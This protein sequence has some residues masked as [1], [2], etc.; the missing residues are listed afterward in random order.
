MVSRAMSKILGHTARKNN[1]F[2]GMAKSMSHQPPSSEVRPGLEEIKSTLQRIM[3]E[4]KERYKVKYLGVFG[5]Y[6]RG[7]ANQT[8]DLDLLVE[9]EQAPTLYEFIRM[10]RY[11]S[12]Q[13]GIKVD[14]VMKKT[15]RPYI[16]KRILAEVVA[17]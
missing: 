2:T 3:P 6:V 16:G 15:L 14:L 4:I 13:V 1:P 8:S 11:L 12:E 17:V 9:F 10:E 7:E 5:S